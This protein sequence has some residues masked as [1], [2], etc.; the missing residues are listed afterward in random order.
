[1][2]TIV[3]NQRKERDELLSRQY[4]T[5]RSNHDED[6][7]L[8]SHLI[9]LITGP[10]RVGKSTQALLMLRDKNFAYLNFDSQQLL[11]AWDANLVMRMLD[12]VY[13]GY[14]YLLLDEVQNLEGWD[15]WVSELYRIGK[16]LVITGSNAKMLSSE[17]A[18]VLTGKYLQV[19][20]LPFS[21][22]EFFDWNKLEL[23]NLKPE[24]DAESKVLTD[25]YMRN[26]GYPEVVASRQLVRS[27]LDTLFDS[28]VWKDVAKRH[29]VRNIT[30]LNNLAMYLVSN[31]CNPLSAN[32]LSEELG[33]SSVNTTKKFMDY[34]HEPYLFYYLSRYNNKLKL[35][36]KAPRKV[37]VVDNGFVAAKAFSLSENL[38]RLLENQVFIELI[39]QGYD[40]EKTMFYYRSR[41]DKEVDFVLRKETRVER[42]VQV[43]YDLSSPKTEK[44][45]VDS[46]VECAGEL[47]CSNLT[48]VTKED[49]RT[50]KK[51]GYTIKVLPISKF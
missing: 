9:K 17:M 39:R 15:M 2:K 7:L 48:I 30:D 40:T 43:C 38:G 14:D 24:Q 45:E 27:Y 6:M 29:N 10:R 1:M 50:I 3:L 35:M 41:N 20:M 42:L 28:I 18:T 44:R 4:L 36:K 8:N 21:L 16:N 19:E 34:L 32:E 5:R 33:F 51:D 12:D 23:H 49:E 46:I 37:Y 26:G 13:P 22:E 25:D 31:F 11:D 47:K